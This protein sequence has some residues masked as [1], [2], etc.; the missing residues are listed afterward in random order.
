VTRDF[1]HKPVLMTEVLSALRPQSGGRY[2][3][4]TLGGAGHAAAILA[5]SSPNGWLYGCDRDG[6]AV[7]A[8]RRRLAPFAGRFEIRRGN[9]SK[10]NEWVPAGTCDGVL[11][12]LGVSSV[13]LDEAGRGFSFQRDGPL[14]MRMD[15]RQAMTAADL[16]NGAGVDE[17]SKIF[18]ELGGEPEARRFARALV[19]ERERQRFGTTGQLADLIERL[20]PR[21]GKKT[22]PA[23]RVFQAL[24]IAVNDEIG[25]LA[26]GLIGALQILKPGGRLAVITFHS[27]EDRVVKEFG[28]ARARDYTFAGGVDVPELREPRA[29]ELKLIN[30]KAIKPGA[31]EAADNPRSRSA[32]LRVMEK[33]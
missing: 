3:D 18:W 17:L 21:R 22:H 1:E 5:E 31:A 11:L 9:F 32:Q 26:G 10:L 20:S 8:A 4:G 30:R 19:R 33:I 28:R 14:D 13:Q 12:D 16:V 24:R 23:T 2:V 27:L 6:D 25:S 7:E 29:P 15:V